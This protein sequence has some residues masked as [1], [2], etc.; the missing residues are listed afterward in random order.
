MSLTFQH[1][2]DS[3][4]PF[5]WFQIRLPS[6]LQ[7]AQPTCHG[8]MQI[9][10]VLLL[11]VLIYSELCC[12]I[13]R[14][15]ETLGHSL[16]SSNIFF[17]TLRVKE[18]SKQSARWPALQQF[19]FSECPRFH[20][21][22]QITCLLHTVASAL[23]DHDGVSLQ[24]TS[25]KKILVVGRMIVCIILQWTDALVARY[26]PQVVE[27]CSAALPATTLVRVNK[28]YFPF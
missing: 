24:G 12:R 22:C 3:E 17:K 25:G 7:G 1:V 5:F 2:P 27:D 14:K 10:L 4:G 6:S 11:P 16:S 20:P 19:A 28:S 9:S 21:R 13:S 26:I 15:T 23:H 8:G 18:T